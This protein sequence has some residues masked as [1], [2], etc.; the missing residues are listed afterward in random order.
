MWHRQRILAGQPRPR[1]G[2]VADAAVDHRAVIDCND[3]AVLQHTMPWGLALVLEIHPT[4]PL[5]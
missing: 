4:L 3:L 5:V 2:Q 1:V